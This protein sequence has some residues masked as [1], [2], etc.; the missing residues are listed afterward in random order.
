MSLYLCVIKNKTVF[1][2]VL[3]GCSEWGLGRAAEEDETKLV[4]G[5]E[6]GRIMEGP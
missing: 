1:P 4:L 5:R 6:G 3:T 2:S